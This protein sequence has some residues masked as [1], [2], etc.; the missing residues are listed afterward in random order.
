[1]AK[2]KTKWTYYK[3]ATVT[4]KDGNTESFTTQLYITGVYC[5]FNNDPA[6]QAA[7][8]PKDV[9]K[10]CKEMEKDL[11]SGELTAIDWGSSI[12][13]EETEDGFTEVQS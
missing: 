6:M 12:T 9:E 7:L 10:M 8:M 11:K 5:I 1:M 13:V 4:L 2:K 3:S